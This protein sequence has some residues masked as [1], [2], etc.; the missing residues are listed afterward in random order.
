MATPR[1]VASPTICTPAT[2]LYIVGTVACTT[3]CD[4]RGLQRVDKLACSLAKPMGALQKVLDS[5]FLQIW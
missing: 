2:P 1:E 3:Q 4:G 5:A